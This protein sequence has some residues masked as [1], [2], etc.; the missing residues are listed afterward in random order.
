MARTTMKIAYHCSFDDAQSKVENTLYRAGFRKTTIKT[1]ESVWKKG[2]G[3]ATAMKFVKVD[4]SNSEIILSAWVQMGL[5]S[6]GGSEMDLTGFVGAL[7]KR[8]LM[9]C[10]E[11]IKNSF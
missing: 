7:P 8:Q 1:G 3:F 11:K 5:G 10:L 6:V 9:N 4:Y 2:I